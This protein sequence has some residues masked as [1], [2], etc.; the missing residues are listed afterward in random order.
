MTKSLWVPAL[1]A[2][3]ALSAAATSAS[4]QIYIGPGGGYYQPGFPPPPPPYARPPY[5]GGYGYGPPPRPQPGFGAISCG[6]GAGIVAS[7]GFHSV[8]PRD[9]SGRVFRYT[10]FRGRAPFE[11]RVSSRTGQITQV[12]R[13]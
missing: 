11:V 2:A 7:Q 13:I 9:C 10:A 6:Q 1:A 5:G 4:A 12:R 8:T 3:I